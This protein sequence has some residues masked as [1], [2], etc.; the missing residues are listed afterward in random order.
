VHYRSKG[1]ETARKAVQQREQ[2][3]G[4]D[5]PFLQLDDGTIQPLPVPSTITI[6]RGSGNDIQPESQSISKTHAAVSV[7][8]RRVTGK[9][10]AY[11]EDFDSRNGT[12]CGI[13]PLELERVVGKRKINFGDYIKFGNS[14]TYFRYLEAPPPRLRED[15]N[16][17]SASLIQQQQL[18]G[19]RDRAGLRSSGSYVPRKTARFLPT[20]DCRLPSLHATNTPAITTTTTTTIAICVSI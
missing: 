5:M 6:G 14:Q 12:Y 15:V 16:D 10:E 2:E 9:L 20:A 11:V 19:S 7:S 18:E 17:P 3:K 13:S 4:G 1:V 8:E